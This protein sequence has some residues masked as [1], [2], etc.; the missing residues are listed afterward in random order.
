MARY[1]NYEKPKIWKPIDFVATD[2][3]PLTIVSDRYSGT[4]SG[5]VYTAWNHYV[6]EIPH[7]IEGDD[8]VCREFWWCGASE[9]YRVGK[10][11]TIAE[12]VADLARKMGKEN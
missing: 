5:G 1:E 9:K 8:G 12:A 6:D 11:S 4:Y 3:Y 10:G 2:I 7:E